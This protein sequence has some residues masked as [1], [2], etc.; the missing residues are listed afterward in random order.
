MGK[1]RQF[2]TVIC[3][4]HEN[5]EELSFHVFCLFYMGNNSLINFVWIPANQAPSERKQLYS[6]R[7]E[8]T[9][10]AQ[11]DALSDWRPGGRGFNPRRD[12]Q[13]SLRGD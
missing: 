8:W 2:L 11:L 7:K 3:Q 10:V 6:K 12:R 5:G 9:S 4:R 1:F 13:Y